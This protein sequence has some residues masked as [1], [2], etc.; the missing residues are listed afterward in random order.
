VLTVKP[1]YMAV[2]P[3]LAVNEHIKSNDKSENVV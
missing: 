3:L 1:V 2:Q